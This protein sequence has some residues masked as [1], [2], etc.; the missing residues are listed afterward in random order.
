MRKYILWFVALIVSTVAACTP[1]P[2]LTPLEMQSLQQR[3]FPV[4]KQVS[5]PATVSV[6]QDLGY[7]V[8]EADL[9]TGLI[10]ASSPTKT[11]FKLFVGPNITRT[12]ATAFLED[13]TDGNSQVRLNFNTGSENTDGYGRR[14]VNDTRILN[15]AIYQAAF[16]KI[17]TAIFLRN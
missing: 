6:F 4:S 13:T 15:P 3:E 12:R 8:D 1:E 2:Q 11:R 7:I 10:T 14:R 17:E 16:E 9:D 5:F